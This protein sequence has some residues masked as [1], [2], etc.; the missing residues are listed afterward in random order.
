MESHKE[1]PIFEPHQTTNSTLTGDVVQPNVLSNDLALDNF[2][3][4][5]THT[6]L[7]NRN[8][9]VT[10]FTPVVDTQISAVSIISDLRNAC[11][12]KI[13]TN[14]ADLPKIAAIKNSANSA[15]TVFEKLKQE[16]E[17]LR[18][19]SLHYKSET[20]KLSSQLDD[21]RK[22]FSYMESQLIPL[23]T[24]DTPEKRRVKHAKKDNSKRPGT[25]STS[26]ISDLEQGTRT[27]NRFQALSPEGM[28]TTEAPDNTDHTSPN[29]DEDLIVEQET[30]WIV[31]TS[32]KKHDKN[33]DINVTN[34][35]NSNDNNKNDK[36]ENNNNNDRNKK[37]NNKSNP[38][39]EP[40]N[41]NNKSN[42]KKSNNNQ[43]ND[44]SNSNKNPN[45][46]KTEPPKLIPPPIKVCDINNLAEVRKYLE[47]VDPAKYKV[48]AL[49]GKVWKINLTDHESYKIVRENLEKE[50]TPWYTYSDKHLRNK[51]VIAK[52]MHESTDIDEIIEDLQSKNFKIIKATNLLGKPDEKKIRKKLSLHQLIFDPS[53]DIKRIFDIKFIAHQKVEIKNVKT[54]PFRVPQCFRCMGWM[55]TQAYCHK[56]PKC[57]KCAGDHLSNL[58]SKGKFLPNPRCINCG[59]NHTA[60]YSGCQVAKHFKEKRA[61]EINK[62]NQKNVQP[63]T[64]ENK[65][66]KATQPKATSH[67]YAQACESQPDKNTPMEM[68]NKILESIKAIEERLCNLESTVYYTNYE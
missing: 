65:T 2:Q 5:S 66:K 27:Q 22:R 48:T 61:S 53:E 59:E 18:N 58:C 50:K 46:N 67:T 25:P 57:V 32:K 23:K 21:L 13:N 51:V 44:N 31:K 68:L 40:K 15:V 19:E 1:Q 52:G 55:H 60:N 38:S 64:K 11:K 47:R 24:P 39:N 20:E 4:L 12:V 3:T 26:S 41:N 42:N 36:K 9:T 28:D 14:N 35:N 30:A 56:N 16:N 6:F 29:F 7:D 54:S 34:N 49:Q 10:N 8:D 63:P 45:N 33:K 37:D 62:K 17:Y 43:T